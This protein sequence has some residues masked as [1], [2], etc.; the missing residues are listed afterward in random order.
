MEQ[1]SQMEQ[2]HGLLSRILDGGIG[3]FNRRTGKICYMIPAAMMQFDLRTGYPAVTTKQLFF[4]QVKGELIGFM[5]GYTSAADFRRV[6]CKIWDANANETPAWLANPYRRGHDDL[7]RIYGAQWTSWEGPASFSCDRDFATDQEL[8]DEGEWLR[9]KSIN[10]LEQALHTLRNDPSNRRII[11]SAWNP[12]ELDRMALPPCHVLY[13]FVADV[14]HRLLHMSMYQRSCDMF[15]GVPFNIAS[16]ALLL[17]IMARLAGFVPG[18]FTHFLTDA[19]IY[20]DHVE[21]VQLQLTRN[22]YAP[23][24]LA[25]D[26]QPVSDD[27][28]IR[29]AFARIEPTQIQLVNYLHHGPIAAKMVV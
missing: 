23:P 7:G 4:G 9:G 14:E 3:Q 1:M 10:Q 15:L 27:H 20:D 26:L 21:Q 16:S 17:S 29:G 11:I 6:G 2:Y 8:Q 24:S 25:L 13:Q 12:G 22:H 18:T 28:E 19:H 5:R